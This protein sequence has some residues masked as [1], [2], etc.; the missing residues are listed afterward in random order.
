[1]LVVTAW[2]HHWVELV[3]LTVHEHDYVFNCMVIEA[4]MTELDATNASFSEFNTNVMHD[5]TNN[6]GT[7]ILFKYLNI[8]YY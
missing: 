4:L 5:E 6:N 1:M 3:I 7:R 8:F 2:A